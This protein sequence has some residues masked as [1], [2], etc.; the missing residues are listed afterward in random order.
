MPSATSALPAPPLAA[1]AL[2]C[3]A[4]CGALLWSAAAVILWGA[5]VALLLALVAGAR[6]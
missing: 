1:P 3:L 5:G 2:V 4:A 6:A